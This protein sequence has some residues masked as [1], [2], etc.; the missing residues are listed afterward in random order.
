MRVVA[1]EA[2]HVRPLFELEGGEFRQLAQLPAG[3]DHLPHVAAD[4]E[5]GQRAGLSGAVACGAVQRGAVRQDGGASPLVGTT[6]QGAVEATGGVGGL[7]GVLRH[8]GGQPP[9]SH[10]NT[11]RL[12]TP[13]AALDVACAAVLRTGE[14]GCQQS[15]P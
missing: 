8:L 11:L 1:P 9:I 3:A 2:Q 5:A 6:E 7:G 13:R 12:N 10:E 15:S 14:A 4:G